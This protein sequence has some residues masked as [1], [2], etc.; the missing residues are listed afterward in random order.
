MYQIKTLNKTC[1][2]GLAVKIKAVNCD[3]PQKFGICIPA[4][5]KGSQRSLC[6]SCTKEEA[7]PVLMIFEA[8]QARNG[9]CPYSTHT[10][11]APWLLQS[12]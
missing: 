2:S 9:N 6:W 4:A 5:Q 1:R 3:I 11:R 7:G 10:E 8:K 12:H